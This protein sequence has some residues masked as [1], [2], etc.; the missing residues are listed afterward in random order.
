MCPR[1]DDAFARLA[2]AAHIFSA[3]GNVFLIA[4]YQARFPAR[5]L[6]PFFPIVGTWGSER[7][8]KPARHPVRGVNYAR[9]GREQRA[10]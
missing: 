7:E 8:R 2:L 4:A 10:D 1:A 6:V 9:K 3:I 5:L